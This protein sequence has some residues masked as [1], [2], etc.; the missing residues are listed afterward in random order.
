MTWVAKKFGPWNCLE[1]RRKRM[2]LGIFRIMPEDDS[3]NVQLYRD[4]GLG[5]DQLGIFSSN[6]AAKLYADDYYRR[7]ARDLIKWRHHVSRNLV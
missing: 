2:M 6:E 7:S 4:T 5:T 3:E 1:S